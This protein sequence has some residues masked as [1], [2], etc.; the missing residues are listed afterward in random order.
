MNY[1]EHTDLAQWIREKRKVFIVDVRDEDFGPEKI[2][3]AVNFPSESF[4][5]SACKSLLEMLE[6][7]ENVVFHCALSKQRGPFCANTFTEFLVEN[8][9]KEVKVF[10][11]RGGFEQWKRHYINDPNFID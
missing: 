2:K 4:D 1:V 6:K 5:Q 10:V 8:N 9:N 7:V 11:L 3:N